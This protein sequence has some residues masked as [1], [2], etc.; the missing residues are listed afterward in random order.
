MVL[1]VESSIENAADDVDGLLIVYKK[2]K[3][4]LYVKDYSSEHVRKL[5]E[6]KNAAVAQF[7]SAHDAHV[8]T[9]EAVQDICE[10][11]GLKTKT[12][13]RSRL[14]REMCKGRLVI[15]V[16]GDG[17]LLDA[18]RK[19]AD[20]PV[21]GVNSDPGHSVGFLCAAKTSDQTPE[22][23]FQNVLQRFLEKKLGPT[24]ITRVFGDVDGTP[25]PHAALNDV[26]IAHKN[27][28]ATTSF[29]V[30]IE[31]PEGPRRE[32][33]LKSSGMWVCAPAGSTA[34]M[35]SAGGEIQLLN[36]R[37]LQGLVRE[38]YGTDGR[39]IA[40]TH[41]FCGEKDEIQLLS[42][43]REGRL[44][45]DGPHKIVAFPLGAKLTLHSRGPRLQLIVSEEMRQRR[46][47]LLR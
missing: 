26:L 33:S 12:V 36:D 16:G 17:T 30:A 38:P 37:R 14:T 45:L 8:R 6:E 15:A 7:Q 23:D 11:T 20:A 39:D 25:L 42:R 47:A 41:F 19:V 3:L 34:A 43:S 32:A 29:S 2:S 1:P 28:A 21:L 46:Q 10:K 27:P 35:T 31:G 13:Y 18:S 9:L 22:N 24:A 44:Y 40:L 4:D 5:L